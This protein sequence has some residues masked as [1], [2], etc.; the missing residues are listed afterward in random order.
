MVHACEKLCKEEETKKES[1]KVEKESEI[2][3]ENAE[4]KKSKVLTRLARRSI[5]VSKLV[6]LACPILDEQKNLTA[7]KM[8]KH[9]YSLYSYVDLTQILGG[10]NWWNVPLPLLS[11]YLS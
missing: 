5:A 3:E 10:T 8:F 1:E 2:N 7:D 9:V 4:G 11:C 6:L